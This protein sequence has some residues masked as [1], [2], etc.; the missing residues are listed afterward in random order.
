MLSKLPVAWS[1]ELDLAHCH[2]TS[3]TAPSMSVRVAVSAVPIRGCNSDSVTVPSS[4]TFVTVT[5]TS[6]S[7][8]WSSLSVATTVM[9]YTLSLPA[10]FGA[11]KLG[12]RLES[13]HTISQ[14]E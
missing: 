8:V 14:A 10:S 6:I 3:D 13:E 5:V 7:S 4:S 2:L 11:S 1:V 9:L 12:D